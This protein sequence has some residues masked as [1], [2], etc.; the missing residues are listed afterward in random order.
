[1]I[2][3]YEDIVRL[4]KLDLLIIMF[5]K[6]NNKHWLCTLMIS[7][8]QTEH[9]NIKATHKNWTNTKTSTQYIWIKTTIPTPRKNTNPTHNKS[10]QHNKINPTQKINA[11]QSKKLF[12][13]LYCC[14]AFMLLWWVYLICVDYHCLI[15]Q[16][17]LRCSSFCVFLCVCVC[18]LRSSFL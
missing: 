15:Y 7:K 4:M 17:V 13:G 3:K 16:S 6:S 11:T 12:I 10:K 5:N 1:M 9:K 8:T 18:V 14:V 2:I